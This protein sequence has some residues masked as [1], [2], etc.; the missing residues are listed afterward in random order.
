MEPPLPRSR[1]PAAR[2]PR[3]ASTRLRAPSP[4]RVATAP[5]RALP[6]AILVGAQRSGTTSLTRWLAQHPLVALGLRKE[7]HFFDRAPAWMAPWYRAH[8]PLRSHLRRLAREHGAR[9]VV[10]D[11]TPSYLFFPRVP[12]RMA[13]VV[14]RAR[15]IAMLRNPIVRALSHYEARKVWRERWGRREE[16]RSFAEVVD[17]ALAWFEDPA[18][19]HLA[20][21]RGAPATARI[22]DRGRYASQLGRLLRWYPREQLLVLRSEDVFADP[23]AVHAEVQRFLGL[24]VTRLD[25]YENPNPRTGSARIDAGTRERLAAF[26]RPEVE[27]LEQLLGRDL[28]WS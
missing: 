28:G 6:D 11:A 18:H 16:T 12:Q 25:A 7:I 2:R 8:F 13:A 1:V 3:A 15:L 22:L 21:L 14:P 20:D 27:R 4:L 19:R 9:P 24:P 17:E 5:L 23:A 10:L 26:Y